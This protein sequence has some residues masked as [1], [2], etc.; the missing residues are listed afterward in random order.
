AGLV[1]GWHDFWQRTIY[2]DTS[3]DIS[4]SVRMENNARLYGRNAFNRMSTSVPLVTGVGNYQHTYDLH[5]E[6]AYQYGNI[7]DSINKAL[8]SSDS[9]TRSLAEQASQL[10]AEGKTGE[11]ITM[12]G[13][14]GIHLTPA[15]APLI[16]A[17]IQ[18]IYKQSKSVSLLRAHL[19]VGGPTVLKDAEDAYHKALQ[20]DMINPT[21]ATQANLAEKTKTLRQLSAKL[22]YSLSSQEMSP[23]AAMAQ[24]NHMHLQ[25]TNSAELDNMGYNL[26]I[27]DR[28]NNLSAS[29]VERVGSHFVKWGMKDYG[30]TSAQTSK[31][32]RDE[33]ALRN[34][35]TPEQRHTAKELVLRDMNRDLVEAK[36]NLTQLNAFKKE[37][38]AAEETALSTKNQINAKGLMNSMTLNGPV[39]MNAQHVTLVTGKGGG[40][41]NVTSQKPG[42]G[43]ATPWLVAGAEWLAGK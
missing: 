36:K 15:M 41:S 16:K 22:H 9:S 14:I 32:R 27:E 7:Q 42:S 18:G 34:A 4:K 12:F 5:P 24:A 17:N 23:V 40:G 6:R 43:A 39:T 29:Q 20:A 31:L 11:A 26:A 13:S 38:K 8:T 1:H 28:G 3:L 35:K 30:F 2:G 33:L 10:L 37:R 19:G 21:T 25:P